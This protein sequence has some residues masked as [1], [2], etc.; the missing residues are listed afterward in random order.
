VHWKK[1][2]LVGVG[3]LGGSLGKALRQG[4]HADGVV[5]YVRRAAS[6][7]E[8]VE[9]GAVDSATCDLGQAVGG[10]GLVV[11]CTPLAQMRP[12]VEGML[13]RLD[14]RAIVTDVGSV[15]GTVVRDLEDLV[16][17]G[18][19]HFVGGHPLAG[20]EKTGVAAARADLFVNAVCVLTPT[21]RTHGPA[22]AEVR[23]FWQLVGARVLEMSAEAHD[24][25]VSR[26]S[27]LPHLVAVQLASLVLDPRY[28]AAQAMLCGSG[29]R[30]T[31]RI[32]SS[33][34]EMWRDIALANRENLDGALELFLRGLRDLQGAL[35]AGDAD[36]VARFFE[37]ARQ[38]REAWIEGAV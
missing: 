17:Q 28:P 38:R 31:T 37:T 22:L 3:L 35:R 18:G 30:D 20:A 24:E 26:S 14:A 9:A 11:L 21:S 8:C 7:A 12:L 27:H 33:S 23:Q 5:G 10:A 16:A 25:L 19:G 32:A 4:R 2:T 15:K 6:I 29:F 1:I 13:P 34:P 36:A